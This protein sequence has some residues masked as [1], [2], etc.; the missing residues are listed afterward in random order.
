MGSL[1]GGD[2]SGATRLAPL[3][4][5]HLMR[6]CGEFGPVLFCC[7]ELSVATEEALRRELAFMEPLGHAVVTLDLTGCDFLDTDAALT[8]LDHCTRW[9][10]HGHRLVVI[11]GTSQPAHLLGV[12]GVGQQIPAF[13]SAEQAARVLREGAR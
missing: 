3:P 1:A 4:A 2:S 11:A 13:A 6:L 12:T 9:Q 5:L 7:G 10:E 8:L